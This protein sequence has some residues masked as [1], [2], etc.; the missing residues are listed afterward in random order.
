MIESTIE[1]IFDGLGYRCEEWVGVEG[2]DSQLAIF[3]PRKKDEPKLVLCI[4]NAKSSWKCD[5]LVPVSENLLLPSFQ[6]ERKKQ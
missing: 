1:E 3:K 6:V 2:S 4:D 5:F